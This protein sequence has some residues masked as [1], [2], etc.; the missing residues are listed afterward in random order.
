MLER[1]QDA[2]ALGLCI[3][4]GLGGRFLVVQAGLDLVEAVGKR[5]LRLEVG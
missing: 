5:D 2:V 3:R 1:P 4:H